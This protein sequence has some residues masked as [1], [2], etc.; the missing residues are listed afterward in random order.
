[1]A[2]VD[3]ALDRCR[4]ALVREGVPG[5]QLFP[6]AALAGLRLL[7]SGA[8]PAPLVNHWASLR[9]REHGP[10]RYP[11]D[12]RPRLVGGSPARVGP[13]MAWQPWRARDRAVAA[14]DNGEMLPRLLEA[15]LLPLVLADSLDLLAATA[16]RTD[17]VGRQSRDL[18]EEALPKARRDAAAWTQE[19]YAWGDTWAL[20]ALARR[21]RALGLLHPYALAIA[22]A[23]AA[24]ARRSGGLVLGT[25]FPFHGVPIVSGS[26]QL[27]SGLVALGYHPRLVASLAAWI[28]GK[29]RRDGSWGDADEDPPD[30]LTT[31]V[32]ADLL[33]SLDPDHDPMPTAARIASR[34]QR[35]GWWRAVG[36]ES[37]WLSV[38][39]AAWL[40]AVDRPFHERYRWPHVA[41]ANRDRRTGLP[42]FGYY[43]EIGRLWAEV[44]GLASAPVEVAFIDLAGFGLLNNKHGMEIGDLALAAFAR[45]LR[46]VPGTMAVRDGGDEFIALGA[47]GGTGLSGRL[48]D[49][50]SR[51]PAAFAE[52]L[53]GIEVVPPRILT[54][55]T[56][57]GRLVEA[58]NRLGAE[59]GP[60]KQAWPVVC[61]EGLQLEMPSAASL[62]G[63]GLSARPAGARPAVATAPNP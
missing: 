5:D 25:R 22:D 7:G 15:L 45:A 10:A 13:P 62:D 59:I 2:T 23:Y 11:W 42:N 60:V 1:M 33:G 19:R 43:T 14:A 26:A 24:S 35:D 44:P 20:W 28:A 46:S 55:T 41:L 47:P 61:R 57:G 49:L 29:R 50:R 27:A 56:T 9:S 17:D 34:Q 39:L 40:V 38:E 51:W 36:P 3:E 52:A 6:V 37:T 30:L 8:D 53:G 16:E 12:I 21:P 18:L 32:A 54:T 63:G 48:A 58:R 4:G 31:F